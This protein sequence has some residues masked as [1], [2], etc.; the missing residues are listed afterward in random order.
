MNKNI[1]E[2]SGVNEELLGSAEDDKAGILSM[3]RQGAGLTTLQILFDHLDAGL[4]NLGQIEMEMIQ[5]NFTPAK[6]KRILNEEPSQQ[7]YNKTFQTFDCV[8]VEG[9]D[10]ATQKMQAFQQALGLREVGV[11]IPDEFI[12]E[13]STLQDKSK[14]IEMMKQQQQQQAQQQ[15]MQMQVQM[16]E[17]KART[18]LANA[19]AEADKG[20][21]IERVSRVDENKALAVERRAE[22]IKDLDLGALDKIKAVKELTT[23]DLTQ[24]QQLLDVVERLKGND[25]MQVSGMQQ[26]PE[27]QGV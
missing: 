17:L 12:V 3:L 13:M 15:Q 14:A 8:V 4:K 27:Q 16:E 10:T 24:L 19:R 26:Q 9:T 11:P 25:A 22:A 1:M 18:N 23:I 20:L 7:F 5:N 6:V 21:A 2:I